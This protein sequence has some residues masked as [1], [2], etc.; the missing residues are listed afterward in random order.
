ML[1][2]FDFPSFTGFYIVPHQMNHNNV[3]S[4]DSSELNSLEK[5]RLSSR[6]QR[7]LIDE[8]LDLLPSAGVSCV[9]LVLLHSLSKSLR[10]RAN[11]SQTEKC[12]KQC[13]ATIRLREAASMGR[14]R[15]WSIRTR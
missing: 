4:I 14:H 9:S 7:Q 12:A 11:S 5:C 6:E 2:F 10:F 8:Q 3:F 13:P 1:F 15:I